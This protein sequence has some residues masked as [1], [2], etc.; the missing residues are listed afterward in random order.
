MAKTL[1]AVD[2]LTGFIVAIALIKDR[3]L[4]N[5]T[6]KSIRKKWKQKA[7]AKGVKR[8][9]IEQGARDIHVSL[10]D[11]IQTVLAAMQQDA[12]ILDL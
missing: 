11:H 5:V 8:E 4:K 2:E 7:F 12:N 6:L 3:K 9:D 10:D 1:R